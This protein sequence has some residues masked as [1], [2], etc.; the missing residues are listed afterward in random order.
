MLISEHWVSRPYEVVTC[1]EERPTAKQLPRTNFLPFSP[2][3]S[4]TPGC[5]IQASECTLCSSQFLTLCMCL[6]LYTTWYCASMFWCVL[7]MLYLSCAVCIVCLG[8]TVTCKHSKHKFVLCACEL[9]SGMM[10]S[11]SC[12]TLLSRILSTVCACAVPQC[13]ICRIILVFGNAHTKHVY[14]CVL[15]A[16]AHT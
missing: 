7:C 12:G 11:V 3:H 6:L 1:V 10:C 9:C 16:V 5:P 4:G 14:S 2:L 13:F 15:C 8:V